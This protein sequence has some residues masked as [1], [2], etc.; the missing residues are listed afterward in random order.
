MRS[1]RHMVI[2][3]KSIRYEI[4]HF[5]M[6]SIVPGGHDKYIYDLW[7]VFVN[8]INI[9]SVRCTWTI[10]FFSIKTYCSTRLPAAFMFPL[11]LSADVV[12]SLNCIQPTHE[13]LRERWTFYLENFARRTSIE[14]S[15][16]C[17]LSNPTCLPRVDADRREISSGFKR[18]YRSPSHGTILSLW[19]SNSWV[20]PLI[21]GCT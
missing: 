13:L 2:A 17:A 15:K 5:M 7:E 1:R 19:Q 14:A 6:Q 9:I 18:T 21:D 8:Q 16:R 3:D 4:L 12:N 10:G 11:Q 20:H